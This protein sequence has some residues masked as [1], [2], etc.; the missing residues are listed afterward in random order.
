MLS[1]AKG[2]TQIPD[3]L[4][5][6]QT[7]PIKGHSQGGPLFS[8]LIGQFGVIDVIGYYICGTEEPHGS[9]GPFLVNAEIW[10]IFNDQVYEEADNRISL[11]VD[12]LRNVTNLKREG[13]NASRSPQRGK[14]S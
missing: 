4:A 1:L 7:Y 14:P 5:Y 10:D 8:E 9:T 2:I 11:E 12:R 13:C 6:K 3:R